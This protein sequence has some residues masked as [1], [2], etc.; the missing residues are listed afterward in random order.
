M[1]TMKSRER[2]EERIERRSEMARALARGGIE[3]VAILSL[4]EA[5]DVLT[6]KRREILEFLSADEFESVRGL[7]GELDRDPGDVSRDLTLLAE[8]GV[9]T[10]DESGVSKSPRLVQERVV[11]EPVI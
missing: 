8:H 1:S 5:E 4:E 2:Q 9:V 6:E 3:G 7:A 10:Y 11:V